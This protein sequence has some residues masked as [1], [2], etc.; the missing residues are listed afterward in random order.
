MRFSKTHAILY[1]SEEEAQVVQFEYAFERCSGYFQPT[2]FEICEVMIL[3]PLTITPSDVK[4][5]ITTAIA[6]D[7]GIWEG[8]VS[9]RCEVEERVELE[10]MFVG[11]GEPIPVFA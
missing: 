8:R 4:Q 7:L 3:T 5:D 1:G 6:E 10:M 9:I 2:E 11:G